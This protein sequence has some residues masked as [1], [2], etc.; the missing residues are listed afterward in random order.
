MNSN[1]LHWISAA[2]INGGMSMP[3][4]ETAESLE[5]AAMLRN[6]GLRATQQRV[7]IMAVLGNATDHPKAD[8]I[9]VRARSV[10]ESVFAIC[11]LGQ[12][13]RGDFASVSPSWDNI[14]CASSRVSSAR[15]RSSAVIASRSRSTLTAVCSA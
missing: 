13:F 12:H 9:L 15:T 6:A 1:F 3:E 2:I 4:I 11:C 5:I 8:D 7:L 10:D 14:A